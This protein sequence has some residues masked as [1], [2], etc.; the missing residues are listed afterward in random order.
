MHPKD[1]DTLIVTDI[2]SYKSTD[3]GKTFVPFKGA[4]GG[5]DNQNIWWNPD[6]PDIMLLVI[7]QGAVVTLNGGADL[8][9]VVHAVD[10]RALSRDDRQRLSVPR[11]RRPAGQRLGVHRE[12]RQRRTDH[13]PRMASGRRRGIRLRRARSARSRPDLRRQGHALRPAHRAGL[14]RR[15]GRRRARRQRRRARRRTARSA[16]SR[17]CSRWSTSARCSTA[18]TCCGRRSTAASTG[19]R[20][21][22]TSRA[23]RGTCRRASAPTPTRSSRGRAAPSG[24]RSS[25]RS[26]PPTVDV[27]RIWIGTDDGVI[28]TTADGGLHWTNVTPPEITDFMKVFTIDPGRFD[29]LT[30]YAAVNTLRLDDMTPHLYRTHDGGK[31]WTEIVDRHSRRRAGQRRARGPEAQGTAVRRHPRR[32]STCRSTTATTGSRCGSTWRLRPCATWS[33]RT[34]TSWSARTAAGSGSSTTSRRCARSIGHRRAGRRAVQAADRVAR[35]VEHQYR[36]AAAARRAD[37]AQP[38][39][40]RDHRLLP[41]VRRAGPGDA[42]DRG[43]RTARSVRSTRATTR[44][45][46][47]IQPRRPC[48]STGSGRR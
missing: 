35:P 6:N 43:T 13:V 24:R 1:P 47:R 3:G 10:R 26:G 23:R 25:T 40:G 29:A 11:L 22:P 19:S 37:G 2:V 45:S 46:A 31:T 36:H 15:P 44:C 8:E 9:L 7:D 17:S 34:T 28:A 5:D 21:A 27:N 18:T 41:E 42:R 38:A 33:S 48:R 32:R 14:E 4:P 16:R 20:S 12:P 39:R 30:A